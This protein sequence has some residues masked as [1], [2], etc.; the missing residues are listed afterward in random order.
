MEASEKAAAYFSS[1]FNCAQSV[2]AAFCEKYG[3]SKEIALKISG[4]FGGGMRCGE[5]CGAVS[6]A[7]MVIGLEKGHFTEGDLDTKSSCNAAAEDFIARFKEKNGSVICREILSCD[8]S[9]V[10]GKDKAIEKNMFDT[11]C[12]DMVKSAAELLEQLGY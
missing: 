2:V 8:I 6:G 5:V 10:Q 1:G 11:V 3:L 4:G 9:T 12:A 7:L